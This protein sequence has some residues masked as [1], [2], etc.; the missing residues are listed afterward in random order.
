MS[1]G[2]NDM[3]DQIKSWGQSIG[4]HLADGIYAAYDAI[5]NSA[6]WIANI[7]KSFLGWFSPPEEGPM[8]TGDKWMPNMIKTL[9]TGIFNSM[10]QL[11]TAIVDIGNSIM[12]IQDINPQPV[13]GT[14]FS[15]GVEPYATGVAAPTQPSTPASGGQGGTGTPAQVININPGM[16]IASKG[17]VRSFVRL[18]E[19]YSATEKT[20]TGA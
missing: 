18:L 13:I 11:D 1:S 3:W 17:E 14:Q 6:T 15:Q 2:I 8:S 20:R 5:K 7:F 12:G 19:T 9:A 16:M 4:S 10:P